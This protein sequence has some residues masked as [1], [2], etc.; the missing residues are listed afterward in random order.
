MLIPFFYLNVRIYCYSQYILTVSA[1]TI[2]GASLDVL[3]HLEKLL[4]SR[5]SEPWSYRHL[6]T[7]TATF[8]AIINSDGEDSESELQTRNNHTKKLTSK[9]ERDH[10]LDCF[11]QPN[12][13]DVNKQVPA[14][15]KKL[16]QI[17][18]LE[19]KMSKGHTL[20]D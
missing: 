13:T 5:S 18:M 10:R 3:A 1:H 7:P 15:R 19:E 16:Q 11:L 9:Q 12:D 17:E 2:A 8:P 6:P 20:D 14:L 4:D